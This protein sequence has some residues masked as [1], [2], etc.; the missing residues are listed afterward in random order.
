M[1]VLQA[2]QASTSRAANRLPDANYPY[3]FVQ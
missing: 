3:T 2:S 1:T